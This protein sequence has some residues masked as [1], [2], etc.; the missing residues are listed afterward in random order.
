[1]RRVQSRRRVTASSE[2]AAKMRLWAK[3]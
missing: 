3:L 2:A 1:V